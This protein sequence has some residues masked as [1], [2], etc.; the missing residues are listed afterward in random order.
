M[1][2]KGKKSGE[3]KRL[4]ERLAQNHH[5]E[6]LH[7]GEVMTNLLKNIQSQWLLSEWQELLRIEQKMLVD[8]MKLGCGTDVAKAK[9]IRE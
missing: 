8:Q 6:K 2:A 4:Q 3:L 9:E 1:S 7:D 5:Q